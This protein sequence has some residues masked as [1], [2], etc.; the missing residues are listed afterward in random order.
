MTSATSVGVEERRCKLPGNR[1]LADREHVFDDPVGEGYQTKEF[2]LVL[3][4]VGMR[5]RC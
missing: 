4:L 2:S 5:Q 1:S 3:L